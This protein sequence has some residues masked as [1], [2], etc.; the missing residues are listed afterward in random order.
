LNYLTSSLLSELLEF[1]K[2]NNV[3]SV[4]LSVKRFYPFR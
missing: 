3:I 4:S 1:H 2:T